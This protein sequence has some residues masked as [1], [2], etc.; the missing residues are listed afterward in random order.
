MLDEWTRKFM[1]EGRSTA[2]GEGNKLYLAFSRT[3]TKPVKLPRQGVI[4]KSYVLVVILGCH[5]I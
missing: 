5:V 4:L 2:L 1:R 3:T